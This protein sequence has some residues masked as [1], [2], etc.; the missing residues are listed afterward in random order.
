[1]GKSGISGTSA[2]NPNIVI[3]ILCEV[4]PAARR[5]WTYV[6]CNLHSLSD[7]NYM[8]NI[9]THIHINTTNINAKFG[10]S[11]TSALTPCHMIL[12][13]NVHV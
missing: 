1:M 8:R 11:G 5:D 10:A 3:M 4:A 7:C 13:C 2:R 9:N 12:Q 6:I